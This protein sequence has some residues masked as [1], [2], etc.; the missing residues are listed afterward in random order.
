MAAFYSIETEHYSLG[1]VDL[2]N[3]YLKICEIFGNQ[4]V[5]L[6]ESF[7]VGPSRDARTSYIGFNPL[8]KIRVKRTVLELDGIPALIDPVSYSLKA[9]GLASS[10]GERFR[11]E[12][13]DQLWDALRT[14]QGAVSALA[15]DGAD[16]SRLGYFGYF[17]YD[18]VHSIERLPIR[19]H[20]DENSYEA[21]LAL[22]QGLMEVDVRKSSA[23][24]HLHQADGKWDSLDYDVLFRELGREARSQSNKVQERPTVTSGTL[25]RRSYESMVQH[26][27][28]HISVGDIYQVQLGHEIIIRSDADPLD[29]YQRLRER[30]PSPY[31]YLAP[32]QSF[33]LVGASPELYVRAENKLLTMRPIAGTVKRSEDSAEN[34][35]IVEQ[36]K[37]DKKEVAEH[38]M[39]VDLC[40]ND[41]GRVCA[42]RQLSVD[43]IL[44]IESYSH[45]Y[46][47]VSSV[48]AQRHK[49]SDIYD[50]IKATFPAGTMTGAPKVRAMEIIESLETTRRGA[51]AGAIGMISFDDQAN[52]ALCIRT[53]VHTGNEYRVRASAGVVADSIPEKEWTET[54]HKMAAVYWAITGEEISYESVG[55]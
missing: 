19:I 51:Y 12:S 30:N 6:L 16:L 35:R 31:M 22:Y 1:E 8:L 32:F 52:L 50:V 37:N 48:T 33:S 10:S 25:T 40:R 53:T 13:R 17:G 3:S 43:E 29:V 42:P 45:V 14:I 27:L 39:L 54:L 15:G 24:L 18:L 9:L 20:A 46:H 38:I 2:L 34:E 11:M 28:E 55:N 41:L 4:N 44:A 23:T 5:F 7:A 36:L 21:E 49:G 47:L 26:A